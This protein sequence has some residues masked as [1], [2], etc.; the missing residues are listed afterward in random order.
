[1]KLNISKLQQGGEISAPWVGY[2]PFFQPVG[3]QSGQSSSST[4]GSSKNVEDSTLKQ[5]EKVL[6]EMVGKGLTNEVNYF[7]QRV[8]NLL[9][10]S[11]LLGQPMSV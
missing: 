9:A 10:D 6:G 2:S 11:T 4:K 3:Q 1:M 5:V 7:S 8:S